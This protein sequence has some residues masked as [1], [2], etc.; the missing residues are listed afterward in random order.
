MGVTRLCGFECPDDCRE[1]VVIVEKCRI[2]IVNSYS[3]LNTKLNF[4]FVCE[5][6]LKQP[7]RDW[8][9]FTSHFFAINGQRC[10]FGSRETVLP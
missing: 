7:P 3:I 2:R 10:F 6:L 8:R 5:K 4:C 1:N 9:F